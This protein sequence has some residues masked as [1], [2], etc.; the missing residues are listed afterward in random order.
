MNLAIIALT[1]VG[2]VE[3]AV[4]WHVARGFR[5]LEGIESRLGHLTDALTL[6]TETAESGFRSSAVEMGRIADRASTA[7]VTASETAIRRMSTALKKGRSTTDIA[8]EERV[9]EGEVS[10]RLHL[11][12]AAAARRMN[13]RTA[14]EAG[15]G[16]LRS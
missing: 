9:A 14:K 7:S 13:T 15:H 12:K 5:R 4:L 8:A 16:A 3:A 1:L 6:L 11:A 2:V 10:L